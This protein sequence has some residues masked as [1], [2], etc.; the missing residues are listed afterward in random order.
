MHA[1]GHDVHMA[2]A[3]GTA[4]ELINSKN[5]WS[6]TLMVIFQPAEE[7]GQGSAKMLEEGLFDKFPRPDFN[8]AFMLVPFLQGK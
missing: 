1:C 3:V 4:K 8:L 7:V 6:G 2:V 5:K